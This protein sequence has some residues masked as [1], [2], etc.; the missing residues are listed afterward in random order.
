MP[1]VERG[2]AS[3]FNEGLFKQRASWLYW[4][5]ALTLLNLIMSFGSSN[6]AS[7]ISL[8]I[9][10]FLTAGV[11]AGRLDQAFVSAIILFFVLVFVAAGYFAIQKKNKLS[12][13]IG[14][15]LFCLDTMFLIFLAIT[16]GALLPLSILF[17]LWACG[18]M[19]LA[20]SQLMKAS[21]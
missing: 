5:A 14:L 16:T 20:I 18:S 3:G 8:G 1:P 12:L 11:K 13:I 4:I 6:F 9:S 21:V 7:S 17:H 10:R 15:G 19:G 2:I